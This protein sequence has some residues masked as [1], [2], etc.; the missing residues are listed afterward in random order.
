MFAAP[1]AVDEGAE[2]YRLISSPRATSCSDTLAGPRRAYVAR[3]SLIMAALGFEAAKAPKVVMLPHL[4][5]SA[6]AL[7]LVSRPPGTDVDGQLT[8]IE[9][10]LGRRL[11]EI[12]AVIDLRRARGC[13]GLRT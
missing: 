11:G 1:S 12:E 7:D 13:G 4:A 5:K 6:Q 9:G 10:R 2:G 8:E 3:M